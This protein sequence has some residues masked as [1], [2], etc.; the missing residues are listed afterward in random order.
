MPELR[1]ARAAT[2]AIFLATGAVFAA[3]ATRIPAT[4]ER[5]NL[6]AGAL[7]VAVLGLEGG[8]IVGLPLGAALVAKTGSRSSLGVGF[9]VYPTALVGVALAPS[10]ITLVLAVALMAAANSVVD[11]AMNAQGVEL[12]RRSGRPVLSALHAGHPLGLVAGGAAGTAAAAAGISVLAHFAA[13][14]ATGALVGIFATRRLVRE[15]SQPGRRAF[16]RPSGRLLLLGIVAFCG[17]LVGGAADNW[18]A[19]HLR[20]ERDAGPGLAAAAFTAYALALAAGRLGGDRLLAR[21]GR[22]RVVRLGALV[23]AA[24]GAIAIAAPPI[25]LAFSGWVLLGLGLATIT[26]AVIGAAPQVGDVPVPAAIATTTTI[27]Y[28]GSFTGPPAIGALAELSSLSA[29]LGLLVVA[30][31]LMALLAPLGLD[32]RSS[33]QPGSPPTPRAP[34]RSSGRSPA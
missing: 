34:R 22:L 23:A 5:L 32:L 28:L 26:P 16:A 10:L 13:A 31:L 7:G 4:Q 11:V 8:A 1:Q 18:S 33:P 25:P 2:F 9:A 29:A 15:A 12:E 20:T 30:S 21:Y 14:A 6:S 17:S 19:V 27:G 3:W 24:G